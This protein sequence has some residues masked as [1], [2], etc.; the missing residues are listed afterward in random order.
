MR[1]MIVG[2]RKW[3]R[4]DDPCKTGRVGREYFRH[5]QRRAFRPVTLIHQENGSEQSGRDEYGGNQCGYGLP[6][7]RAPR[8]LLSPRERSNRLK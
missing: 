3:A 1:A 4:R 8:A 2:E 5:S 7:W 6:F